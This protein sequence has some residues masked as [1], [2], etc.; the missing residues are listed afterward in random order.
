MAH[1]PMD[2]ANELWD[3]NT[4][5]TWAGLRGVLES[6][7]NK[8]EGINNAL[9]DDLLPVAKG[10]ADAKAPY[11]SSAEELCEELNQDI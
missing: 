8:A 5:H 10:L 6:H 4:D 3:E 11:P 1:V 2:D 9:I 7:R